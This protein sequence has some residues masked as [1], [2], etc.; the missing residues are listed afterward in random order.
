MSVW[1][2]LDPVKSTDA[3]KFAA[4]VETC[5]FCSSNLVSLPVPD[6]LSRIVPTIYADCNV[7]DLDGTCSYSASGC[8]VC[9]WWRVVRSSDYWFEH[10]FFEDVHT[11]AGSLKSL[12]VSDVAVPVEEVRNYLVARYDARYDVNPRVFEETVASVFQGLGYRARVT[13]YSNDG[14]VDVILDSPNS[15]LV[16]VQ[17]KRYRNTIKV[18]SIRSLAGALILNDCTKGVFVTTS[19]FQSGCQKTADL[20]AVRGISIELLN[21]ARFY[22]ALSLVQR[23]LRSERSDWLP[24]LSEQVFQFVEYKNTGFRP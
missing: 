15:G 21:A 20:F 18:E 24:M 16:G 22:D 4:R 9:G 11:A 1:E 8:E 10:V 17:V 23:T 12:D 7:H 6:Y 3:L 5:P 19:D 13:G 2:Y 14:G